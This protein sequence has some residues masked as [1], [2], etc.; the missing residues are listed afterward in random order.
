MRC[1]PQLRC[2]PSFTLAPLKS[3]SGNLSQCHV[4]EVDCM[5]EIYQ[6][7]S[8]RNTTI[9]KLLCEGSN[10]RKPDQG[11]LQHCSLLELR[12]RHSIYNFT[13]DRNH[14]CIVEEVRVRARSSIARGT[15]S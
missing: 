2:P 13:F 6:F 12:Y 5:G 15:V 11:D 3:F 4:E 9:L 14:F 10:V 8:W 1:I 7:P